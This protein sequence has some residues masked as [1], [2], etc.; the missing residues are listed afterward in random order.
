MH[1]AAIGL[2]SRYPPRFLSENGAVGVTEQNDDQ[3]ED[4][5]RLYASLFSSP[6]SRSSM[7][8]DHLPRAHDTPQTTKYMKPFVAVRLASFA[9]T[10]ITTERERSL[11]VAVGAL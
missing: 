11:H 3:Q 4:S 5:F 10:R 9:S 6:L 8:R 1:A 7:P 2:I